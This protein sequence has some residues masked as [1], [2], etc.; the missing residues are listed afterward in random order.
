MAAQK[1]TKK[2]LAEIFCI[3]ES[4][5]TKNPTKSRI[6]TP[7]ILPEHIED[8]QKI[9]KQGSL[10]NCDCQKIVSNLT[11][12]SIFQKKHADFGGLETNNIHEIQT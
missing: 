4:Q 10:G 11:T 12:Q 2:I 1:H 9:Q 5:L 3:S 6:S 7:L 8:Y